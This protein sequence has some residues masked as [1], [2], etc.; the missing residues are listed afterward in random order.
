M[1]TWYL[2]PVNGNDANDGTTFANRCLTLAGI[3]IKALAAGDTVRVIKSPDYVATG[4]TATFHN[5][6]TSPITNSIVTSS[7]IGSVMNNFNGWYA[8]I[9]TQNGGNATYAIAYGNGT[10][11]SVI[12]GSSTSYAYTYDML[13]WYSGTFPVTVSAGISSIVYGAGLF[14]V[15]AKNTSNYY[16]SPTGLPGSWTARTFPGSIVAITFNGTNFVV[17]G[18][19]VGYY[20]ADGISWTSN[21]IGSGSWSSITSAPGGSTIVATTAAG[22]TTYSTNN[23]TSWNAGTNTGATVFRIKYSNGSYWLCAG[24]SVS[25]IY[26]SADGITWGTVTMPSAAFW[27][28]VAYAGGYMCFTAGQTS[29]A[30]YA[31][32][33]DNGA[34]WVTGSTI[35]PTNSAASWFMLAGFNDTFYLFTN[36]GALSYWKPDFRIPTGST[37]VT[38]A[39][40]KGVQVVG[41]QSA[42]FT[43]AAGFTT[44]LIG[45]WRCYDG[46]GFNRITFK[47]RQSA[48]T[49][50]TAGNF[51]LRLCSDTVG[52]TPVYTIPL[53]AFKAVNTWVTVSY[54]LGATLTA[55]QI[56]SLSLSRASNT[57]AQTIQI[58]NIV[59]VNATGG[60]A[61]DHNTLFAAAPEGPWYP[62]QN[63]DSSSFQNSWGPS[64]TQVVGFGT[65]ETGTQTLYFRQPLVLPASYHG[66][67]TS[68][69]TWGS[70]SKSGSAGL[71]I[72][73]SGGWD[74]T[75]MSTQTGQT[76]INGGN[77]LAYAFSNQSNR[78]YLT[79]TD[80]NLVNF[81]TGYY[82]SGGGRD[83]TII[84][85]DFC[86]M[87]NSAV[88][89]T[90]AGG[91]QPNHNYLINNIHSNAFHGVQVAA[92]SNMFASSIIATNVCN[93]GSNGLNITSAYTNSK[94]AITNCKQNYVQN[95]VNTGGMF[96]GNVYLGDTSYPNKN[97]TAITA[98]SVS[99]SNLVSSKMTIGNS[100]G[101]PNNGAAFA[102]TTSSDSDVFVGNIS[103]STL[104]GYYAMLIGLSND[105]RLYQTGTSYSTTFNNGNTVR[106]AGQNGRIVLVN[107]TWLTSTATG[108]PTRFIYQNYNNTPSDIRINHPV[109]NIQSDATVRNTASGIS[110]KFSPVY[111]KS[112]DYSITM[113][114]A[115][116]YLASG[117]STTVS[118][119]MRRDNVSCIPGIKCVGGQ[120]SGIAS[121]VY[122]EASNAINT[123]TQYSINLTATENGVVE[124]LGYA[125][126]PSGS[127][128]W[129]DDISIT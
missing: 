55:G 63:I 94:I 89:L 26:K 102:I 93:N 73:Y 111:A 22:L 66:T 64:S 37:N 104:S 69:T 116:V 19:N 8:G 45:Y 121:D 46:S 65:L 33:E 35:G 88:A 72:T 86:G 34:T 54:D 74:S 32:S 42:Q 110:W 62:I 101:I 115:S 20:S 107:S 68:D 124:I 70:L 40:L 11:V 36:N 112:Y 49:V 90:F 5:S 48:G 41:A 113:P 108:Q 97:N 47:F 39:Y 31:L 123:W 84:A 122:V 30:V 53:P 44:G 27:S 58:D 14:V 56:Q 128:A 7:P 106:T 91:D 23:G 6:N 109:G 79:F 3:N 96:Y 95:Y 71:P 38:A 43:I 76:Y 25:S 120:I 118:I 13:N 85:Q 10:Y 1:S 103:A 28:D 2:D 75:N 77:G 51:T 78:S 82:Q 18:T 59:A 87:V 67:A 127:N 80:I 60:T 117:V 83:I 15:L 57:G 12:G 4:L 98:V 9:N 119:W 52:A 21:S 100:Q 24:A 81:N 99:Q 61:M 125:Y 105:V 126:G 50:L 129:L 29:S 16:T 17:V 92:N 114:V